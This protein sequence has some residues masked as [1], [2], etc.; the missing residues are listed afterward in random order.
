MNSV[1][2]YLFLPIYLS[3]YQPSISEIDLDPNKKHNHFFPQ[4]ATQIENIQFTM[5]LYTFTFLEIVL[6]GTWPSISRSLFLLNL[7]NSFSLK[8]Q[9]KYVYPSTSFSNF[10]YLFSK[11]H[12][13]LLYKVCID[14]VPYLC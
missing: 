9:R 4:M 10:G 13:I 11:Y 14:V 2:M 12:T 5:L 1:N 6:I 7:H 3:I 8:Q